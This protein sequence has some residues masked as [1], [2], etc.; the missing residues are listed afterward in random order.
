LLTAGA[1]G[2]R[3]ETGPASLVPGGGRMCSECGRF[4]RALMERARMNDPCVIPAFP[5]RFQNGNPSEQ[6]GCDSCAHSG[7]RGQSAGRDRGGGR[8]GAGRTRGEL[9]G[10]QSPDESNIEA[11]AEQQ[12]HG[13]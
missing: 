11:V 1:G 6:R 4:L 7:G 5:E 2:S 10:Y 12:K 8:L 3:E 13:K 9:H